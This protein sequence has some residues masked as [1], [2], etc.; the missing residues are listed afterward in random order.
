MLIV[1][2][3]MLVYPKTLFDVAGFALVA[4]VL[5][6]QWFRKPSIQTS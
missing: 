6:T 5:F 4:F 3:I 2:G 1:A